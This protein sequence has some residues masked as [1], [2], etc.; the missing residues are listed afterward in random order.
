MS[1]LKQQKA[2]NKMQSIKQ[3]EKQQ[4]QELKRL[5]KWVGTQTR[6]AEQ[7][8]VSQQV[9]SSWVKRGRI[10]ATSATLVERKTA[11]LFK[12]SDLRPDVSKWNEG[13]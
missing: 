3:I 4:R 12:R 10:S 5:I 13:V 11:G 2:Q 8:G 1:T 7:L 9:V 6:L